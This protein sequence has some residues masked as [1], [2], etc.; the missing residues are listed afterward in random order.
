MSSRDRL[1]LKVHSTAMNSFIGGKGVGSNRAVLYTVMARLDHEGQIGY[2]FSWTFSEYRARAIAEMTREIADRYLDC[3]GTPD[4][5]WDSTFSWMGNLGRIGLSMQALA[6][7]DMAVWDATAKARDVPVREL[8]GYSDSPLPALV[9]GLPLNVP[10]MSEG[11]I[12]SDVA[13]LLDRGFTAIKLSVD[14][15]PVDAAVRLMTRVR[16]EC[17]PG[18]ALMADFHG[19]QGVDDAIEFARGV[20]ELELTWL[21]D[22]V[23][24]DDLEAFELVQKNVP[25]VPLGGGQYADGPSVIVD[26]ANRYPIKA[27]LVSASRIGGVTPWHRTM[28][29]LARDR[30]LMMVTNT[31]PHIHVSLLAG[32]PGEHYLEYMDW[33]SSLLGDIRLE[34]GRALAPSG[35]GW[36]FEPRGWSELSPI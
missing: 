12:L 11:E 4:D 32:A 14:S 2:G 17:G 21:E 28:T 6:N 29:R 34:N 3:T 27:L 33:W 8:L 35:P 20:S 15:I 26:Y 5:M 9:G 22:P 1:S 25:E 31:L 13:S 24:Q 19:Q 36:G 7:L 23:D 10:A 30:P 16:Q 18:I